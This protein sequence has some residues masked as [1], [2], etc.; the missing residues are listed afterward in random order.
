MT[1]SKEI[2]PMP[3]K[4]LQVLS[5]EVKDT[6]EIITKSYASMVQRKQDARDYYEPA[7]NLH[8]SIKQ[9][10]EQFHKK[11]TAALNLIASETE[12][13]RQIQQANEYSLDELKKSAE[14]LNTAPSM[15]NDTPIKL[16][17]RSVASFFPFV[18]F[19]M[20]AF[21]AK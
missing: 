19:A 16:A 3:P 9:T 7:E 18:A 8:E 21:C 2:T 20:L 17:V 11:A 1:E 15:P 14:F 12:Q 4:L 13:L 5:S 6:K 10:R